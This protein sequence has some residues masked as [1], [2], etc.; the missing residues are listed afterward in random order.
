MF[1]FK[2]VSFCR[3]SGGKGHQYVPHSLPI[4]HTGRH[5]CHP[6]LPALSTTVLLQVCLDQWT[7]LLTV[8]SVLCVS[9]AVLS[10]NRTVFSFLPIS[11]SLP[12]Y[13]PVSLSL[14]LSRRGCVKP[15]LSQRKLTL[16]SG[17]EG[18]KRDQSTS[19]SHL[20]NSEVSQ[21]PGQ[22]PLVSSY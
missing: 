13:L 14:S 12:H 11:L 18:S 16:S 15:R 17:L 2:N 6:P 20:I 21:H 10:F 5:G 4:G 3:S 7:S 1:F 22:G 8:I 9:E 19:M